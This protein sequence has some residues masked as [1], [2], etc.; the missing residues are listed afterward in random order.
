MS[1]SDYIEL[2]KA[3][4]SIHRSLGGKRRKLIEDTERKSTNSLTHI[5]LIKFRQFACSV[6]ETWVQPFF[7]QEDHLEKEMTTTQYSCS[8][9][10]SMSRGT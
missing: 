7:G 8:L 1:T 3:S 10:N 6:G 5:C 2:H 4:S 9:E